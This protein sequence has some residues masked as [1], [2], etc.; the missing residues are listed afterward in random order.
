MPTYSPFSRGRIA[1]FFTAVCLAL[2]T[3][4]AIQY[5]ELNISQPG[6]AKMTTVLAHLA[7]SIPQELGPVSMTNPRPAIKFS[8][9]TLPKAV[10]D[11]LTTHMLRINAKGEAQVYILMTEVNGENLNQLKAVGVT[12]EIPDPQNR[13]VQARIPISRIQAVGA[14]PFVTYVRLPTYAVHMTGSVNTEGDAILNADQARQ[15]LGVDGSNVFVGVISDGLKGIFASGSGC[16]AATGGNSTCP[17]VAGGPISTGDLPNATGTRNASEVLVS[18][19]SGITGL[20]F[21][22]NG[23]LEGLPGTACGFA[24]AGA[25]GTALLEIIHDIAPGAQLS[26]ANAGTDVEFNQAVNNLAAG[27]DIVMDDLGFFGL[28]QDG[29][30]SVSVNT[31]AALNNSTFPI[32]GY[33]TAVGNNS[34]IHYL[35]P[36][37]DSHTDGFSITGSHGDLHL[38]QSSSTTADTLS[39]GPQ[40][41]DEIK[42]Q[43]TTSTKQTT[44]GEVVVILSWDDPFGSSAN[45]YG[46]YL[47]QHGTTQVV[48]SDVGKTCEGSAFPVA[49]LQ[50]VNNG[51][52][53]TFYDIVI[54]NP[55][56]ASAA[57]TL[58]LYAFSPECAFGSIVSLGPSR[59]KLN[60]NTPSRSVITEGDAG[61]SPVSVVSVGA[62]CSASVAAQTDSAKGVFPNPSCNDT[63]N[64]TIEFFSSQGPTLDGRNKPDITGIDGV[65]VTGAGGFEN[66]FFGTSASTPHI[67]GI[68]ALLLEA[69]VCLLTNVSGSQ[70]LDNVSA[71]T[72]LQ[73]LLLDNADPLS[74][75]SVFGSGRANA[76]ASTL[77]TIPVFNG[78]ST[79]VVG[80]NTPT[81]ASLAAP[82]LGFAELTTC[83]DALLSWSGGCGTS[84]AGST[85]LNCPFGTN[86]VTVAASNS[87]ALSN[88]PTYSAPAN[89]Q[90]VVTNFSVAASPGS[91]SI[92]AGQ[93]ATYSVTASTQ[94]GTFP[95]SVSLGCSGLPTS[96]S[97][98][99]SPPSLTPGASSAQ[100]TLSI[101]TTARSVVPPANW[102]P[103]NW[104][105]PLFGAW[106]SI[107]LMAL[108]LVM[109]G[110]IGAN[111]VR[112]APYNFHR[113]WV[114]LS[115]LTFA[116]AFISLQV[117]CGGGGSTTQP[118]PAGT[119]AGT[120]SITISGT[121]GTLVQSSTATLVV[122]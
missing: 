33:Y 31:A 48:A 97:C 90:I 51:A 34:D 7:R 24:G 113:G 29:T 64:T 20:S 84:A 47:V 94:G 98:S 104:P 50:F 121:S 95:N 37:T 63:T 100:S 80:G 39:L 83:P 88:A 60:F 101:T 14:L 116:L 86:N 43:G 78:P 81:G 65:S 119:P 4:P 99:F 82:D 26:F 118:P 107:P 25:E 8:A 108:L 96:A 11:A 19:T 93:T 9:Q 61:G 72:D 67:A 71:R 87:L 22:A 18:S 12:I 110:A 2:F 59:A 41:F 115:A 54:Q 122:Q 3:L 105:S 23:D 17:G 79:L 55:S 36:Y 70:S 69:K 40:T 73:N 66:P 76:L 120:Y 42:L 46:L 114:S 91:V 62:I 21:Q 58:N 57:K 49:C 27:N 32:R 112:R 13:R 15:Q 6:A 16:S 77:A 10:Q 89:I 52:D 85:K 68:A 45:N 75:A 44:G 28:Q 1:L 35:A 53:D 92:P 111:V 74:P 102:Q 38:F 109:G 103:L 117:A 5:S 56:N 106:L 30:S